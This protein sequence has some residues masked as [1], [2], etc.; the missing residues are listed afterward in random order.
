MRKKWTMTAAAVLLTAALAGCSSGGD[1]GASGGDGGSGSAK[2]AKVAVYGSTSEPVIFWDPSESHSNEIIVLNN[3]YETLLR[4]NAADDSITPV[5]AESYEKSEDGLTWTFHLKKNVKFHSGKT[6]TSADVKKSFERTI[7]LGKGAAYILDP[8]DTIET[9]DDQTVVF[10]LKYTATLDL[11]V[12]APYAA[13]IYNTD[14]LDKQGDDYFTKGHE[15]GTGPYMLKSWSSGK[16]VVL[17]KFADY[18]EGWSGSHYENVVFQ[19]VADANTKAQMVKNGEL[20]YVD[21]LPVQQLN[22]LKS[23]SSVS[24]VTTPSYQNLIGFLNTKSEKLSDPKVREALVDAFP[25]D[26]VVNDV[27]GGTA[28]AA[29]GPLPKGLWG[30]DDS[31]PA[32]KYDLEKAKSLLLEAGVKNLTLTLTY[33]TGD[34]NQQQIAE[35][36]KATLAQIGVT[37]DVKPMPWDSQWQL[38]KATDPSQRQDIFMMYWWPDYAN[39]YGFMY[40]LFHTE[41]EVN[42]NMSY[43]SNADIDK[44]IDEANVKAGVDRAAAARMYGEAQAKLNQDYPAIWMYDQQYVRVINSKM[45]GFVDNPAYPN[46]VFWYNVHP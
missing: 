36:Y 33:T 17:T 15:D 28:T 12:S 11:I 9:P 38:A 42:Y 20:T 18:H 35:L 22:A 23:D 37:L 44:L 34:S 4:Y 2:D 26:R 41:K 31:L 25:Y 5:L 46:V 45:Q 21:M 7:K 14:E 13:F 6:M 27:M 10:K 24:V 32:P 16:P 3:I 19:T 40:S 30:H 8:I 39:P 43:Y 29:N 1:S